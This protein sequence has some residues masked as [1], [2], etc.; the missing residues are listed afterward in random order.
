MDG[1]AD[2]G[3][4]FGRQAS[5]SC[6]RIGPP[7]GTAIRLELSHQARAAPA[8]AK[9]VNAPVA[10]DA[11][12]PMNGSPDGGAEGGGF[13]PDLHK[14]ILNHFLRLVSIAQDAG[15]GRVKQRCHLVIEF[16]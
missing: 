12:N 7:L 13:V 8:G 1:L 15:C 10:G 5:L 11:Q 14:H 9:A 3:N 4:F 16:S 6:R 2:T